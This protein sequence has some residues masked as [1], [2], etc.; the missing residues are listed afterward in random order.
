MNK[1]LLEI[2]NISL[3]LSGLE[4]PILSN[5][6]YQINANDFII[7][8]GSNGSGKSSLLK[9]LDKRYQ[10]TRGSITL[11]Q[12]VLDK[13]PAHEFSRK[14]I[15]LTQNSHESLFGSLTVLENYLIF[16]QRHQPKLFS[17]SNKKDREF[18]SIYIQ[19]F[20]PNLPNKLDQLVDKL[21]GGE[22]QA[23]ALALS[24]LY[25]PEILLLD[26]HTSALDPKSAE[27]LMALTQ[28]V[29]SD[30]KITCILTTH[31]LDIAMQ[32][33]NRILALRQGQIHQTIDYDK[34]KILNQME[35]LNA[36]Y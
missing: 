26:E 6:N 32:Y 30:N 3:E 33:G 35:L 20:N 18:F 7:I 36:C 4:K 10:A 5:L 15:T 8:L 14:V 13:I 27:R 12:Q 11:N 1:I 2:N 16:K 23:L 28:R 24:V 9:L 25:P 19:D 17:F 21:S 31:D 34:K 22:K 29:V